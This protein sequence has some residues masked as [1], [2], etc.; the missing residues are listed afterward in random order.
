MIKTLRYIITV[1][2]VTI[3]SASLM[4]QHNSV[5]LPGGVTEKDTN[6]AASES[7]SVLN[8]GENI[9]DKIKDNI[10][11]KV[12]VSKTHCYIGEP[13]LVTYK[14][15]TRLHSQSKVI[16]QPT[17]NGCSVIEMTTDDLFPEQEI[18]NN[19][20]YKAYIIR[21]VQLI[22][23]QAGII[24]LSRS[25]VEN[26]IS[27]FQNVTD[28]LYEKNP[29]T[30]KVILSNEPLNIQVNELP[31]KNKPADFN[32]AIGDFTISTKVLKQTD[33]VNENNSLQI[34][35][36][37]RG[38]FQN[39]DLPI[40][41]WPN[42]IEHFEATNDETIDDLSFPST[43]KKI[44]TIPFVIKQEGSI[45]IPAITFSYFNP[46]QQQYVNVSST[47]ITIAAKP[48][49][50]KFGIDVSKISNGVSNYKYL[51]IIVG[52]ALIVGLLLW[53]GYRKKN[54]D[55]T[56]SNEPTDKKKAGNIAIIEP[57][58]YTEKI[59]EL[60]LE[61]DDAQFLSKAKL[62]VT[63][64]LQHEKD[65]AK[66]EQLRNIVTQCDEALYSSINKEHS[67]D[68]ILIALEKNL[69]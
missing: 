2:M 15:Y 39:V 29:I 27:F 33:T 53:L 65:V 62:L 31:V 34:I 10:F 1:C 14:L 49:Q 54:N 44:F 42:S 18:I 52:L 37:G 20:N 58:N 40:V 22:P 66:N 56:I 5:Q 25:S 13:V 28:A 46:T 30:K 7:I 9:D 12:V 19:K 43:G 55:T 4:A 63:T 59:N 38:N 17:F 26:S 51:W 69:C 41:H 64:A 11:I 60:L 61:E 57:V 67:R 24:S 36:K 45:T 47:P 8:A 21:K 35:I 6:N 50:N 23:L 48:A 68:Q 16:D 3:A 32:N